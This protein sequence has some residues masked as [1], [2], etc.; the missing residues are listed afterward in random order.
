LSPQLSK[1]LT[2][3]IN[4][5]R[6]GACCFFSFV[7]FVVFVSSWVNQTVIRPSNLPLGA[8][9]K[10]FLFNIYITIYLKKNTK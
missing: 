10:L 7:S 1:A 8:I 5:I 6:V 4:K 9:L 2:Q 3:K